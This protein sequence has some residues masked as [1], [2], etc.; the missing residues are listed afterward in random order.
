[1]LVLNPLHG[2]P[3]QCSYLS[4]WLGEIWGDGAK[5]WNKRMKR[6]K[7]YTRNRK[8]KTN[9]DV[10]ISRVCKDAAMAGGGDEHG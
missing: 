5:G 4:P 8:G 9:V 3:Q 2:L 7:G 6:K 1:M 10:F